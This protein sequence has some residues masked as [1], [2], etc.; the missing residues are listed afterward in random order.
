MVVSVRIGRK[1]QE[2]QEMGVS[3]L[4]A[5]RRGVRALEGSGYEGVLRDLARLLLAR[6]AWLELRPAVLERAFHPPR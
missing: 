4:E 2:G 5:L 6:L 3:R 1:G